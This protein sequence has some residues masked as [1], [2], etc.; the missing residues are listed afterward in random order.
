[1]NEKANT[2]NDSFYYLYSLSGIFIRS[3]IPQKVVHFLQFSHLAF[4]PEK[5]Q[6]SSFETSKIEFI[7]I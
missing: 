3:V 4:H 2:L 1:M 5:L 6:D 7:L